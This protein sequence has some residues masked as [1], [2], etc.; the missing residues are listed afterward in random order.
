MLQPLPYDFSYTGTSL[1]VHD[2]VKIAEDMCTGGEEDFVALLGR[3]KSG[4][5]IKHNREIRKRLAR[6]SRLE[7]ELLAEGDF[8]TQQQMA[9]LA[10]CKAH[11]F[12]RDFVVEVIREKVMAYDFH[13]SEGAYLSFWRMKSEAHPEMDAL[14]EVSQKKIKQ[15]TMKILEQG[16]ILNDVEQK[17]ILQPQLTGRLID[18]ILQDNAEWLKVFLLTDRD[19]ANLGS[20][21]GN[22]RIEI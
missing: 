19:I 13:L 16:G 9:F 10:M 1:R 21:H 6:L 20:L 8:R 17:Q 15:V 11:A 7:L 22:D 4:T 2:M 5:G 18:A 14:K 12:I 3:G